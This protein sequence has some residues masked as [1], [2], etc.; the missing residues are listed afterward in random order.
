MAF[1]I[2]SP[3]NFKLNSHESTE[4]G[5]GEYFDTTED[6]VKK[7]TKKT[8]MHYKTHHEPPTIPFNT[9]SNRSQNTLSKDNTPGPGSYDTLTTD[10]S[11]TKNIESSIISNGMQLKPNMKNIGFLTNAKRF[12]TGSDFEDKMPGPGEYEVRG[13]FSVTSPSHKN[14]STQLVNCS[15]H[16]KPGSDDR[17]VSIP[18]KKN[19]GYQLINGEMKMAKDPDLIFKLSGEK[20][21]SAGPG[22]YNISSK[23]D[24]NMVKWRRNKIKKD[25]IE[26]AF[27]EKDSKYSTHYSESDKM[28]TKN[29]I[30]NQVMKWRRNIYSDFSEQKKEGPSS[31]LVD[32]RY[33]DNPGPGF[34]DKDFNDHTKSKFIH[35]SPYQNFGS[36]CPKF[37]EKNRPKE[38]VGPGSY[39]KQKNKY[40]ILNQKSNINIIPR[41]QTVKKSDDDIPAIEYNMKERMKEPKIGP[42]SYDVVPPLIKKPISSV[43][44][45]GSI[46]ER[47]IEKKDEEVPAPGFYNPDNSGKSQKIIKPKVI[48]KEDE[49]EYGE[50]NKKKYG[51]LNL[52]K[53]DVPP[54]GSYNPGIVSSIQYTVTSKINPY[55]GRFVPFNTNDKR[56]SSDKNTRLGPGRYNLPGAFDEVLKNKTAKGSIN[57]GAPRLKEQIS[58]N[59][60][61]PGP[62][63]YNQTSPFDWK[64]KSFNVLFI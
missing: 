58:S 42:G 25:S 1:V 29:M 59:A 57:F 41:Y 6:K 54:V 64:K 61:I 18:G 7:D 10:K 5:P 21:D 43:T 49:E 3:R 31:I 56:F 15:I 13:S 37:Y 27:S 35:T 39:F 60:D 33:S 44:K 38:K 53:S 26:T 20:N 51:R 23:W 30:F 36:N 4:V 9:T 34:Y 55:Q 28:P 24:K 17:I 52:K 2:R 40:E 46:A 22:Q 11:M 14:M 32:L 8:L 50:E 48:G 62:G 16:Q 63:E 47:F 12:D 19:Y 45:F